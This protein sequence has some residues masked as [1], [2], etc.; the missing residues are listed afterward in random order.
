M[1][2]ILISLAVVALAEIPMANSI[3]GEK[4]FEI[5]N[6]GNGLV[7]KTPD[8]RGGISGIGARTVTRTGDKWP[9][10]PLVL[11]LYLS[12]LENLE[13]R[14]GEEALRFSVLSTGEH[15][16]LVSLLKN[17]K[18]LQVEKDGPLW[19]EVKLVAKK[20]AI[21]LEDGF[22]EITLPSKFLENNP[23]SFEV[24]WIDFYR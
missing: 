9:D 3:A 2:R 15:R 14:V 22:F 4:A 17:G 11:K 13:I 1:K 18:E 16:V 7:S 19:A 24:R 10:E 8:K 20:K 12:G 6:E 23:K 5:S 21:P